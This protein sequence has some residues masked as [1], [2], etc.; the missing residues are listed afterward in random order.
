MSIWCQ[1]AQRTRNDIL[2][3]I[4]PKI[5]SIY[6][7]HN[8]KGI[9]LITRLHLDLSYLCEYKFEHS[10][11]DCFNPLCFCGNDIETSTS[12]SYLYKRENDSS[13]KIK[14]IDCGILERNYAIM[15][16]IIIYG[17]NPPSDSSNTLILNSTIVYII[18]TKRL[19]SSI[20]TY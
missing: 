1:I 16:K 10:F 12:L 6:Y 14:S 3:L 11:H 2:K 9:G 15:T 8:P 19:D 18:S 17:G 13:R 5:N 20:L 7:C 4:L